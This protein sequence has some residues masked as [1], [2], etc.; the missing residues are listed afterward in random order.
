M[1]RILAALL[2]FAV[3]VLAQTKPIQTGDLATRGLSEKD[4]PQ[5]KELAPGVYSYEAAGPADPPGLMTTNSLIVVTGEGVLVA[6][7]QGNVPAAERMI[8]EI[9]KLTPQPVKYLVVCSDHGDHTGGNAAFKAAFPEV[10]VISSPV[11]KK[12]LE[13]SAVVPTE[14]VTGKRVIALGG[15]RMEILDIGRAHTGGD[16]VVHIPAAKVLFMSEIYF[17]RLFPAMRAAYPSEW[18]A[19]IRKAQGLNAAW[20]VPGHGFVDDA[21]TLK[22]ELEEA[23]KAIVRA[24]A[25]G[26]RLHAL[27]LACPPRVRGQP[28]PACPANDRA[29]WGPYAEWTLHGTEPPIAL[30][31]VFQEIEGKLP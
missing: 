5:V 20:Y 22:V 23:R 2:L 16:L 21:P 17:H 12:A 1:I 7:G 11:S 8:A 26:K 4:Y 28:A 9:R 10:A 13:K 27:G 3:P 31:R 18:E 24:I 30:S 19:S 6:D 25:E 14:T 29:D 15:M